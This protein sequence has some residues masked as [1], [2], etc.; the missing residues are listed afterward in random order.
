MCWLPSMQFGDVGCRAAME[1]IRCERWPSEE[2]DEVEA[3]T[4][5]GAGDRVGHIRGAPG[6]R[7]ERSGQ[8]SY[9]EEKLAFVE[10]WEY[11][12]GVVDSLLRLI[13]V[14]WR[15]CSTSRFFWVPQG[16]NDGPGSRRNAKFGNLF[17]RRRRVVYRK[18]ELSPMCRGGIGLDYKQADCRCRSSQAAEQLRSPST[19]DSD[20][21]SGE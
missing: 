16:M 7:D 18:R 4:A 5:H 11:I 8:P 17:F 14:V 6:E 10:G 21:V 12:G 3:N 19:W 9:R 2:Q 1:A 20:D 13:F 15:R